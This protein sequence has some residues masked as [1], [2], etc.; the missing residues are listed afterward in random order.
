MI[1]SRGTPTALLTLITSGL[2]LGLVAC[3]VSGGLP[4]GAVVG[5]A[6]DYNYSPSVIQSGSVQQFWW[7][8]AAKNP[9]DSS[10]HADSILY[11]SMDTL[12]HTNYGPVA[13]LAETPGA[14]DEAYTCNPRVVRGLFQNPLGDG[15]TY[16]Y[17][18]YYVG[19][20]T[21]YGVNNSIGVAFSQD[22]IHWNKYPRA[23]Y[24][25]DLYEQQLRCWQASRL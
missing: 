5:V 20:A 21:I 23:G 8:S 22:G 1:S 12:T 4:P 15:Q 19:T 3:G 25:I 16:S 14:W 18:M 9:N 24:S 6:R 13:V 7:C 10:Q 11:E 2:A 17:A